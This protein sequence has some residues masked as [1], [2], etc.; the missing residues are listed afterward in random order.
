[1]PG[2][3][4]AQSSQSIDRTQPKGL[5]IASQSFLDDDGKLLDYDQDGEADVYQPDIAILPWTT[6][7]QFNLGSDADQ[8]IIAA[9]KV[10]S[11]YSLKGIEV[12]DAV[13]SQYSIPLSDGTS[14]TVSVDSQ[15][16]T[17]MIPLPLISLD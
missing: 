9:I 7:E 8:T 17:T 14:Y 5:S 2:Y 11:T 12:F 13:N 3:Y 15:Y 10:Q 1:M 6:A 16:Q 4:S